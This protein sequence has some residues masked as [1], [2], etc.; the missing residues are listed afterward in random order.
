MAT[1]SAASSPTPTP[2]VAPEVAA[3]EAA[4]LEAYR[5]YWAAKVAWYADPSVDADSNLS[6]YA[7]DT[8]LA[9][10]QSTVLSFRTSRIVVPGEPVLSPSVSDITLGDKP[11]ATIHDCVDVSNWQAIF[12]DSG[13][14]A[15]APGQAVRV[16][17][18]AEASIFDGRWVIRSY[19]AQR[20]RSC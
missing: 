12:R 13:E 6:H 14:N 11:A 16:V 1:S 19:A 7:I 10:A 15:V 3:A 4:V 9:D 8:A 5:Q 17:A 2:T 20:D 18:I